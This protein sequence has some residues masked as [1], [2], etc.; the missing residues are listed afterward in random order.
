MTLFTVLLIVYVQFYIISLTNVVVLFL[1]CN[2]AQARS[3]SLSV[4]RSISLETG[5][6]VMFRK[7]IIDYV[8]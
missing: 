6:H 3:I 4:P 5:P 1:K 8:N 7:N 2:L